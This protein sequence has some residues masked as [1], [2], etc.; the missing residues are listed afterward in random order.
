MQVD[1]R[2][3]HVECVDARCWG[4]DIAVKMAKRWSEEFQKV[5]REM[6]CE[7]LSAFALLSS[8]AM[9]L[10]FRLRSLARSRLD[11]SCP[12]LALARS[13]L[14]VDCLLV[15]SVPYS[16]APPPLLLSH[17]HNL[18]SPPGQTSTTWL[19]VWGRDHRKHAHAINV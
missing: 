16:I 13:F 9:S 15:G 5:S 17:A 19:V 2:C 4:R 18:R 10:C 3:N 6:S 1:I 8:D 7:Y 12:I 14:H 11:C